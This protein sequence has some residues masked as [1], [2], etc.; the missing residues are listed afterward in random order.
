[1]RLSFTRFKVPLSG[2]I[3]DTEF[4]AELD[5][6]VQAVLD[7][8]LLLMNGSEL[9]SAGVFVRLWSVLTPHAVGRSDQ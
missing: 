8:P 4:D 5:S 3:G 2:Y 7:L 1:M 6:C 9:I